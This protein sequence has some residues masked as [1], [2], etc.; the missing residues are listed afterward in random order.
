MLSLFFKCILGAAVVVCISIL[1][2]SKAFYIA[3]LVPLFPTFAL[4]AHVIVSQQQGAEAL[5]K[6]A[7]FGL[8][9]LIP[10]AIYLFMVYIFA[11]K[12]S[13]WS[14][15]SLATGCWIIAAA[16]LIYGWKLFQ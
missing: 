9:S 10:Y 3:G 4:I 6:T 2:K 16:G 5:R 15:L 12:M 7:L 11:P 8:W 13:M 1:S 14:C